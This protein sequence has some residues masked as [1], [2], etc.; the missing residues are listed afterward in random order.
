L[1][2]RLQKQ[3]VYSKMQSPTARHKRLRGTSHTDIAAPDWVPR[4]RNFYND[5]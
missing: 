4:H 3:N 5:H 1:G 2:G